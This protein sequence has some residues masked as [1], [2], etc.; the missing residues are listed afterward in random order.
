MLSMD[1]KPFRNS[2]GLK[3]VFKQAL[4][5]LEDQVNIFIEW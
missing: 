2:L 4:L 1:E 5:I 3:I